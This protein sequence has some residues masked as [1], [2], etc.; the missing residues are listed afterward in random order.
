MQPNLRLACETR[1]GVFIFGLLVLCF[2]L[3]CFELLRLMV[4]VILAFTFGVTLPMTF[5][6]SPVLTGFVN[7]I[8]P[9]GFFFLFFALQICNKKHLEWEEANQ[10]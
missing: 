9:A 4:H 10:L 6:H 3:A 5:G 7:S 8:S 1:C 2:T